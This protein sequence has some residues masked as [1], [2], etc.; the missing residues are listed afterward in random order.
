MRQIQNRITQNKNELTV[1]R[2]APKFVP[3]GQSTQMII[4]A[5]PETDLQIMQVSESLYERFSLKRVFYSAYVHHL[6]QV[7]MLL[8]YAVLPRRVEQPASF[9]V[10]VIGYHTF[11]A[12]AVSGDRGTA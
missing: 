4:G 12:A 11:T 9:R 7:L 10:F 5:T 3:A 8:R 2:H 1:Y 6:F